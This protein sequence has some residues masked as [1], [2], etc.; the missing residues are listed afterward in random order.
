MIGV[1]WWSFEIGTFLS[2]KFTTFFYERTHFVLITITDLSNKITR[3]CVWFLI[4]GVLGTTEL[5][6][7]TILFQ[8]ENFTY[9]VR[10]MI[11]RFVTIISYPGEKDC[12]NLNLFS[13]N[14]KW[15]CLTENETLCLP[16]DNIG[17]DRIVTIQK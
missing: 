6:A 1:E 12:T 10:L 13:N 4:L 5:G 3:K 15:K 2:G 8:I 9:M 7:Q 11:T 16:R 14:Y 17:R